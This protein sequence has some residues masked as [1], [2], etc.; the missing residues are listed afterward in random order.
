MDELLKAERQ[1]LVPAAAILHSGI[2]DNNKIGNRLLS[3]CLQGHNV[4]NALS[5]LLIPPHPPPPPPPSPGQ[6]QG[7]T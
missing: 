6:S 3:S 4:F 2:N 7:A 1:P 5:C